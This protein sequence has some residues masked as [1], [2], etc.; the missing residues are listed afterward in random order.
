MSI[1]RA[2]FN[3]PER[4]GEQSLP[5]RYQQPGFFSEA[6]QLDRRHEEQHVVR[7]R[8]LHRQAVERIAAWSKWEMETDA[9][10]VSKR[11][12]LSEFKYELVRNRKESQFLAGED[13]IL[14]AEFAILD[15]EYFLGERTEL[16]HRD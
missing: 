3:P 14:Q 8:D 9:R 4:M 1:E 7:I 10:L 6:G 16:N 11:R 15:D 12:V 5:D 13:P 2:N